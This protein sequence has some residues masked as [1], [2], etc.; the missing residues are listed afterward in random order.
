VERTPELPPRSTLAAALVATAL[1]LVAGCGDSGAAG[2]PTTTSAPQSSPTQSDFGEPKV[3][4]PLDTSSIDTK[5]CDVA[6]PE[7]MTTLP[8]TVKETFSEDTA[9]KTKD[10]AWLFDDDRG[11]SL[12]S[13]TAG[14]APNGVRTY[15]KAEANGT[16][17]YFAELPPVKGYPAITF[18][19]GDKS[20]GD[21]T[22]VVG[23]RDDAV[24]VIGSRLREDHPNY[25]DPCT[26]SET[27]AGF[28]IDYLK[29][30]Q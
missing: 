21:C 3:T 29:G 2:T 20:E 14:T 5:P 7:Q 22:M 15:Y 10:C 11:F 17:G 4:N 8:G 24:Y 26:V 28:A 18:E 16:L 13:V 30:Q 12:G 1:V 27:V 25:G 19:Q 9:I 23:L 6:T